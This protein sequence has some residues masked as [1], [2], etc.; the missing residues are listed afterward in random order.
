MAITGHEKNMKGKEMDYSSS[1]GG[2]VN[3]GLEVMKRNRRAR[4]VAWKSFDVSSSVQ[5]FLRDT[6]ERGSSN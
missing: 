2:R 1:S 4:L 5:A 3:L 6:S